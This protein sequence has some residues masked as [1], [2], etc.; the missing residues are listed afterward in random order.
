MKKPKIGLLPLYIALYDKA[1][2]EM[3]P[4]VEGFA[5]EVAG[6]FEK[7]G[8]DV[9]ASPVCTVEPEFKAAVASFE[10]GGAD[11]IVTLHLAYSPSLES[12]AVLAATKLP[13]LILNT[14][15]TLSFVP[16]IEAGDGISYNH[17]IHGVQDMANLLIRG[18]KRFRIFSIITSIQM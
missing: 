15:P 4:A 11:A 5:R 14:T 13:I 12:A 1:A 9:I 7:Q 10:E 3:R 16:T 8:L 18:G 2:P 17:G 6:L